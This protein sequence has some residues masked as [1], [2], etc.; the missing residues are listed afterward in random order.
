MMRLS[1]IACS[2]FGVNLSRP[3]VSTMISGISGFLDAPL[4]PT[5]N[6]V[7]LDRFSVD[8]GFARAGGQETVNLTNNTDTT[9][10][11]SLRNT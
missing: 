1:F 4:D 3:P 10:R 11:T 7:C 2:C 9:V 8:F 5:L 6:G